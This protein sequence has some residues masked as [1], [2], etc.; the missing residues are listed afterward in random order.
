[1]LSQTTAMPSSLDITGHAKGLTTQNVEAVYYQ[2][3]RQR[4]GI[5]LIDQAKLDRRQLGPI[6]DKPVKKKADTPIEPFRVVRVV[7][8]RKTGYADQTIVHFWP[9]DDDTIDMVMPSV[10]KPADILWHDGDDL[11]TDLARYQLNKAYSSFLKARHL[12]V[13]EL[14]HHPT[15]GQGLVN[16]WQAMQA[17]LQPI[18]LLQAEVMEL[19]GPERVREMTEMLQ[20]HFDALA[21]EFKADPPP[22]LTPDNYPSIM[23]EWIETEGVHATRKALKALSQHIADSKT[24]AA[25]LAHIAQLSEHVALPEQAEPLDRLLASQMTAPGFLADI[26]SGRSVIQWLGMLANMLVGEFDG[27]ESMGVDFAPINDLLTAGFLPRYR[28]AI[29]RRII[30]EARSL[31]GS[32]MGDDLIAELTEIDRTSAQLEQLAP[33]LIGDPELAAVWQHRISRVLTG[34]NIQRVLVRYRQATERLSVVSSLFPMMRNLNNRSQ[35]GRLIAGQLS[36]PDIARELSSGQNKSGNA[37]QPLLKFHQR[38][39]GYQFDDDAKGKL[40]GDID[41]IVAAAIDRLLKDS[42]GDALD[43]VIS[44]LKIWLPAPMDRGKSRARVEAVLK[45]SIEEPEFFNR[46]WESFRSEKV[47]RQAHEALERLLH[48]YGLKDDRLSRA[49]AE[50]PH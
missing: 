19:E 48:E 21:A 43:K 25:K 38:L 26:A 3:H 47:R 23:N 13:E 39:A 45:A 27:N 46:F 24:F 30:L 31:A 10:G 44:L 9:D 28:S 37:T 6:L 29:R 34:D 17:G 11:H 36:I 7:V 12:S 41:A 49:N 22:K 2:T 8:D 14:L 32:A 40:L 33:S 5:W 16:S 42:K 18:G 15:G 50:Q 1:M 20:R 35:L 4:D